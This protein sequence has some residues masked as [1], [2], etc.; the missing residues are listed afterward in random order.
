MLLPKNAS[1][2]VRLL[3]IDMFKLLLTSSTPSRIITQAFE[4][5]ITVQRENPGVAKALV[6]VQVV[7]APARYTT[8]SKLF[9]VP[10]LPIKKVLLLLAE[11]P[12]SIMRSQRPFPPKSA[13]K[14]TVI[15]LLKV[16]VEMFGRSMNGPAAFV[17]PGNFQAPEAAS[18]SKLFATVA[19][20]VAWLP[21]PERSRTEV[22]VLKEFK[23][24]AL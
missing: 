21:L 22:L 8:A 1:S 20:L 3:G 23:S 9:E 16:F 13:S 7:G 15:P 24:E 2:Q 5:S 12:K 6:A 19:L 14:S 4:R 10:D 18:M 17:P 11:V